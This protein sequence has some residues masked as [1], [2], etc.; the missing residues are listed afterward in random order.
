MQIKKL[1]TSYF[2]QPNEKV[3]IKQQ[4]QKSLFALIQLI[5]CYALLLIVLTGDCFL[6][7]MV[8]TLDELSQKKIDSFLFP[9]LIILL[10]LHIVPFVFWMVHS[11]H[12]KVKGDTAWHILTNKRIC[13]V[14][15]KKPLNVEYINVS[16]ITGFKVSKNSLTLSINEEKFT[17]FGLKNPADFADKI[18]ELINQ[19][20]SEQTSNSLTDKEEELNPGETVNG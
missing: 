15:G 17:I 14:S 10:V 6:I 5:V 11:L 16:E 3:L 20:E 12:G 1:D 9:L 4:G 7:G 2:L 18:E 8:T 13:I 19:E